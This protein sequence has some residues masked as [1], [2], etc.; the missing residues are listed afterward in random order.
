MFV[1]LILT[2]LFLTW[3]IQTFYIYFTPLFT[4]SFI[5]ITRLYLPNTNKVH[6]FYLS[7]F[8]SFIL[9]KHVILLLPFLSVNI[10]FFQF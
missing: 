5:Y 10:M 8:N 9:R 1:F 3:D 4:G 6:N 2:K 7:T